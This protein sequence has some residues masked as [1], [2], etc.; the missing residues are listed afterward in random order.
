MIKKKIKNY[1]HFPVQLL[2]I[3]VRKRIVFQNYKF[4][5]N[6]MQNKI[7]LNKL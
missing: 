7:R 1:Y 5:T 3:K 6:Y 2:S 4:P